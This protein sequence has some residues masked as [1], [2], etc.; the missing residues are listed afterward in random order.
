MKSARTT[1]G[2]GF[3]GIPQIVRCEETGKCWHVEFFNSDNVA[4]YRGRR[5][6]RR[7]ITVPRETF[8]E[9]YTVVC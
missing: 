1:S 2:C 4:L 8:Y 3:A 9:Y 5:E 6:D 7:D